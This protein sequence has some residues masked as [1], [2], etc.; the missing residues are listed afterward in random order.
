[1]IELWQ[2]AVGYQYCW[3]PFLGDEDFVNSIV[4]N[5]VSGKFNVIIYSI[6]VAKRNASDRNYDS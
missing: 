6:K 3:D 1:M 4:K 2:S 5:V